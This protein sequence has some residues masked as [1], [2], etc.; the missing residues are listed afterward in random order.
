METN[1]KI[2]YGKFPPNY[3]AIKARLNPPSDIVFAYGD[4]I[5]SPD[6]R[7]I[8][9]HLISH[10]LVHL[11]QQKKYPGGP[12][13]WWNRYLEDP[14]FRLSQEVEGLAM[15]YKFFCKRQHDRNKQFMALTS[16]ATDLSSATYGT[17]VSMLEAKK[18]IRAAA[19]KL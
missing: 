11:D 5:Y 2:L 15:Q 4:H 12:E 10:E 3:Q 17:M 7:N 19:E 1:I 9:L 13:A 16:V 8:P 6:G 18:L 14:K